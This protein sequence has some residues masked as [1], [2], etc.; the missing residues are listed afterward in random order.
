MKFFQYLTIF[1]I[2]LLFFIPLQVD[3]RINYIIYAF[4]FFLLPIFVKNLR[5]DIKSG[6]KITLFFILFL[7]SN[8]ISTIFAQD[9]ERSI[10]QLFL[11]QSYFVIFVSIRSIFQTEKAKE[12]LVTSY[13]LLV[14][15]LSLISL[16]NTLILKYVN[17]HAEGVSFM[18]NYF[19]HNHISSLLI[20]AIPL[21]IYLLKKYWKDRIWKTGLLVTGCLLLVTLFF[22]FSLGSMICLAVSSVLVLARKRSIL[23]MV[24]IVILLAIFLMGSLFLNRDFGLNKLPISSIEGRISYW[25][26]GIL[27]FQK[28][29]VFGIGLVSNKVKDVEDGKIVIRNYAAHSFIIQRLSDGG[30]LGL[31]TSL[32]LIG[33]VLFKGFKLA[34]RNNLSL[35]LCIGLLASSLNTLV[36]FDWQI[37]S[38]FLIFW[39]F[40]GV[41]NH[42]E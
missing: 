10:L 24:S 8:A 36:D 15:I 42:A 20:F 29:P 31:V 30:L 23:I 28:N 13:L 19:G 1:F 25:K 39:I 32:I 12:L 11:Y 5:E 38:V 37:A 18:W 6:E 33:A 9:Q 26:K 22:S 35:A 21:S 41:L 3:I 27:N 17:R 4:A 34:F 16:Y 40:A 2:A 14:T 7:I